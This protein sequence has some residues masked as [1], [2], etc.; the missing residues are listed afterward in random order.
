MRSPHRAGASFVSCTISDEVATALRFIT[1]AKRD[2]L[3]GDVQ[4]IQRMLCRS[5]RNLP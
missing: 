3:V 2:A 1:P 4:V 5:M